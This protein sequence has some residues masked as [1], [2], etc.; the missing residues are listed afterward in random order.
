MQAVAL[1][2]VVR[3]CLANTPPASYSHES[4]KSGNSSRFELEEEEE[5]LFMCRYI[6][7]DTIVC[8]CFS[9]WKQ[10]SNGDIFGNIGKLKRSREAGDQVRNPSRWI[11]TKLLL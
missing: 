5:G 6:E 4:D 11:K 2:G 10:K 9:F 7:I 1:H 3:E 8:F